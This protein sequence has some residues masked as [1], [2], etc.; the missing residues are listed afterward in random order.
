MSRLNMEGLVDLNQFDREVGPHGRVRDMKDPE[1]GK[2]GQYYCICRD[3]ESWW[4]EGGIFN[5]ECKPLSP[6]PP[7]A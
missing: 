2:H 6:L 7:A 1:E 4:T 3:C 5:P